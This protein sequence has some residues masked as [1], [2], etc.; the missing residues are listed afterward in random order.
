MGK[1]KFADFMLIY[2]SIS[3][4]MVGLFALYA[5]LYLKGAGCLALGV[6]LFAADRLARRRG[7]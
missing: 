6:G 2:V 1:S 3:A 5:K 7:F 4:T